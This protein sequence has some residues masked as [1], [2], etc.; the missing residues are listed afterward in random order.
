[1][2]LELAARLYLGGVPT[3]VVLPPSVRSRRGFSGCVATIVINGRL[4]NIPS[5]AAFVTDSVAAGCTGPTA[6]FFFLVHF[7][8]ILVECYI[9]YMHKLVS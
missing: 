1:V 6:F 4:Y 5:D 8:C 3:S 7:T 9:R 2:S